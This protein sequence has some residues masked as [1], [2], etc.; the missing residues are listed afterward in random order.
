M[1]KVFQGSLKA[2]NFFTAEK[3]VKEV[4]QSFEFVKFSHFHIFSLA[5]S[6][7]RKELKEFT[8]RF[9]FIKFAHLHIC[10]FVLY[11]IHRRER[12]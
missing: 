6:T 10:I 1:V 8:Q 7:Q 5:H 12:S 2:A 9:E 3:R 11:L 4:T